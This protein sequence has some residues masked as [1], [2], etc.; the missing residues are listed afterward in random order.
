MATVHRVASQVAVARLDMHPDELARKLQPPLDSADGALQGEQADH[1]AERAER[2]AVATLTPQQE[3]DGDR[4]DGE[5][6][7]D[8]GVALDHPSERPG[9]LESEALHE[10]VAVRARMR[11]PSRW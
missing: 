6:A 9:A 10:L 4:A 1:Q 8:D 5:E 2:S 11:A 3:V 7:R